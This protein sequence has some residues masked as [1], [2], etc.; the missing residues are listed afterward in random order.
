MNK[1]KTLECSHFGMIN[2]I[3]SFLLSKMQFITANL[4]L[5]TLTMTYRKCLGKV[6]SEGAKNIVSYL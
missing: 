3:M 2:M 6:I 1:G 4:Q 5:I